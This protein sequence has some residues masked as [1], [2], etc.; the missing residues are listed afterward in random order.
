MFDLLGNVLVVGDKVIVI[1]KNHSEL[2]IGCVTEVRPK[3]CDVTYTIS[4]G[5]V[6]SNRFNSMQIVKQSLS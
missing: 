6:K 2:C 4:A 3:T 1:N 5:L